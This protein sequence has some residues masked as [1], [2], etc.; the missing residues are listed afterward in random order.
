MLTIPIIQLPKEESRSISTNVKW[1]YD[2][3]FQKGIV[4]PRRIYGYEVVGW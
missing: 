3:K 1:T 4:D 2:K